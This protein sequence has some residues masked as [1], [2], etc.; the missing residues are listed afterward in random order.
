[1][2]QDNSLKNY[3]YDNSIE[4][5]KLRAF[6]EDCMPNDVNIANIKRATHMKI[7]R[8]RRRRLMAY[9]LSMAAVLFGV[10]AF[11]T[12]TLFP[13]GLT[14][15]TAVADVPAVELI[16][17]KVPV[18]ERMT[19]MLADGTRVVANSCSELRYPKTFSGQTREVYAKGEVFFDV[20]Q[21]QS[22][23]FIVN[24]DGVKV[25]VLGTKFCVN[26]YNSERSQVVL[27]E[28]CVTATLKGNDTVTMHPGNLLSVINGSFQHLEEVDASEYVSWTDGVLNLH[29]DD[30]QT[31]VSRLNN[32][33]DTDVRIDS[34]I[35]SPRLYGK[36]IYQKDIDSVLE[37]L[38]QLAKTRTV[39]INGTKM[40]VR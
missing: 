22:H 3:K 2:I 9:V 20:A 28:G 38:N 12:I 24:A 35:V 19:I 36:L 13:S 32:Y 40:V 5:Q 26:N 21:D 14:T 39:V 18:G 30:L 37:S 6:I 7:K 8:H 10:V 25:R 17:V 27:L 31:I 34:T 11:T 23:P 4:D 16:S 29:G 1:M 15:E 33:Y